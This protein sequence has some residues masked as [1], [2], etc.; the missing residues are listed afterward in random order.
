LARRRER[1]WKPTAAPKT[2]RL[3]CSRRSCRPIRRAPCPPTSDRS[4]PL[5]DLL[6]GRAV[7]ARRRWFERHPE[8]RRRLQQ[9][10]I[11][12]GNLSVGGTGKTPLV[13]AIAEWL[14]GQGERPAILSRGYA[15]RTPV[16]GVV[17]VSD[18]TAIRS[19]VDRAGDEPL[20]LAHH[21]PHAIVCVSDDRHLAGVVAERQL[22]A[23]VHLLDDGFQHV[24]LARDFDILVTYAGEITGGRV[25][26]FGRL[27]EPASCAA[28][29]DFVVVMDAD[30][31]TA[32]R[33]AWELGISQFA[34]A[35][36]VM[37]NAISGET[38]TK[39][40]FAVA[41]IARPAQFFD[42]LGEAGYRVLGTK[43]FADHHRYAA[44]DVEQIDAARRA[45][46]AEVVVT[47][48][49]DAVR[50]E[51]LGTLPFALR[52]V[53]MGLSIDGLEALTAS[54]TAAV[55]RRQLA[56]TIV[57]AETQAASPGFDD[58]Q[59]PQ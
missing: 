24:R 46:G 9:P 36:R 29:A 21:I 55:E 10:V 56:P 37:T 19:D 11:S 2:S 27:R 49:K 57:A 15:R 39:A 17:V 32:R 3:P 33:E 26:P 44:K 8:A 45:A 58:R 25:L 5:L 16:D 59:E 40:V 38:S 54:M 7:A 42:M 6:Y 52:P 4:D 30:A 47:T 50:F 13:A 12:V 35:R 28:R 34:C 14:I 51:R 48:A 22:G 53:T 31:D 43:T 20:M 41:G 1:S 23:T 18:G